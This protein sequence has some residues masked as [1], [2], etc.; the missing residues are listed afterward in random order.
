MNDGNISPKTIEIIESLVP[1]GGTIL[2]LGSGEGTQALADRDY[3]MVSV[4]HSEDWLHKY[5]STYI[6][7]DIRDVKPTKQFPDTNKWYHPL[8]LKRSLPGINYDLLL[9][10]GPPR[11]IGEDKVGRGGL[12]KYMHFFNWSVPVIFDDTQREMEWKV[13][14]QIAR[15]LDGGRPLFT[16]D[17]GHRKMAT[18]MLP[19][20]NE[21]EMVLDLL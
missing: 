3:N 9:V 8:V 11:F 19:D 18:L 20:V 14:Y 17:T 21:L 4:E 7:A 15:R 13:A 5:E 12:F 16:Y 6:H 2:E 10:D 1:R